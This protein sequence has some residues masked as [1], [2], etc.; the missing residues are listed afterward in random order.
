MY[1]LF[2]SIFHC[3]HS[4]CFCHSFFHSCPYLSPSCKTAILLGF[5]STVCQRVNTFSSVVSKQRQPLPLLFVC[6]QESLS[7]QPHLP[8]HIVQNP[9]A[10]QSVW[11]WGPHLPEVLERGFTLLG[12]RRHITYNSVSWFGTW[13][14]C[15]IQLISQGC[16]IIKPKDCNHSSKKNTI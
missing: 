14:S 15:E 9:Y 11:F 12:L 16:S 4:H 13:W 7:P 2:C 1:V 10:T 8:S 6:S 3:Y 5:L